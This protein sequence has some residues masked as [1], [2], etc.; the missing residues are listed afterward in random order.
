MR[1]DPGAYQ[2]KKVRKKILLAAALAGSLVT[3]LTLAGCTSM[4]PMSLA[5]DSKSVEPD[6]PAR[7]YSIGQIVE[8]SSMQGKVDIVYTPSISGEEADT[9]GSDISSD[10]IKSVSTKLA[11]K[12]EEIIA[13]NVSQVGA[14]TVTVSITGVATRSIPKFT[15]YRHLQESLRKN[16]EL[17]SMMK[18]YTQLGTRFNVITRITTADISFTVT[19]GLGKDAALDADVLRIINARLD[20]A[21]RQSKDKKA[22]SDDGMILAFEADPKMISSLVQEKK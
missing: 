19:D 22:C 16:P 8:I 11:S 7:N 21:F 13:E 3:T 17:L 14:S 5:P 15:V 20:T 2:E 6:Y 10:K 18:N 4:Q 9:E 12:I 1:P